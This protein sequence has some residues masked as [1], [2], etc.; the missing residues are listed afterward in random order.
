MTLTRG[1][2]LQT[3][4]VTVG[5]W[6]RFAK[7]MGYRSEAETDGGAHV[8]TGSKWEKKD[9][10]YWDSPGFSQTDRHPVTC[11]SWNDA[12]AFIQWV[13]QTERGTYR[14]PT[15]AEWEYA[16]RA[17]STSR[18]CFGDSDSGLGDYAWYGGNSGN[19]TH[20]VATKQSNAWGLYD[21]HGNVWEWCHDWF[22]DYPSGAVT[23]P[24]G[25]SSGSSR[26]PRR[27]L[28]R[29]PGLLPIGDSRQERT[30]RPLQRPGRSPG[31][32]PSSVRP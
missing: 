1:Y 16:A 26:V 25:P 27:R 10:R 9:G 7:E 11:V 29:R 3:N 17:G 18:F 20:P 2:Y 4:E 13:N 8:W 24:T 19:R 21:M 14:L 30:G 23:D 32:V 12:Q 6:C 31:L 15:E 22:G 28:E 5:Q